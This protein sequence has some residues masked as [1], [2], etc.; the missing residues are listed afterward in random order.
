MMI[1]ILVICSVA[2]YFFFKTYKKEMDNKKKRE[3]KAES[4]QKIKKSKSKIKMFHPKIL[5]KEKVALVVVDLQEAF[6]SP[7]NDFAQIAARISIAVRGFQI[8]R[9]TGHCHRAI[10]ERVGQNSRRNFIFVA[11]GF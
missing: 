11:A 3:V 7:I 1:L 9:R 8:L 2:V 5:T 6:R 4:I 10:P